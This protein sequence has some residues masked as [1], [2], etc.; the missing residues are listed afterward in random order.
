MGTTIPNAY[1]HGG[2]TAL[3]YN[4]IVF[5][6]DYDVSSMTTIR[7]GIMQQTLLP[8]SRQIGHDWAPTPPYRADARLSRSK[9]VNDPPVAVGSSNGA[10]QK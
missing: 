3:T 5:H 4:D 9:K 6:A 10:G 7:R 8:P 2:K 1:K